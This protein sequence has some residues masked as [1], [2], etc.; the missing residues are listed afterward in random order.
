MFPPETTAQRPVQLSHQGIDAATL[1][2]VIDE[3]LEHRRGQAGAD[4]VSRHVDDPDQEF[5]VAQHLPTEQITA[6]L[7]IR[8][9]HRCDRHGSIR[10]QFPWQQMKLQLVRKPQLD[11]HAGKEVGAI[12]EV[13]ESPGIRGGLFAWPRGAPVGQRVLLEAGDARLDQITQSRAVDPV[14]Q[15]ENSVEVLEQALHGS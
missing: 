12:V 3:H 2:H 11:I 7:A 6:Q 15:I 9:Q 1:A 8:L 5:A 4:T 14:T 13:D 10:R